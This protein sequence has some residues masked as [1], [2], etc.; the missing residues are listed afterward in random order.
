MISVRLP[1][2]GV[3]ELADGASA[4]DLAASI[5]P[6]LA[7]AA[8]AAKVDGEIVDLARPLRDGVEVQLLT[9]R[10]AEAL[11]VLRHSA[12]HL[13]ADAI[14]RVFPSAQLTIG[15]AIEDGFYYDIY[16]PDGKITP[17]DFPKI[18]EEMQRIAER[19]TPFVRCASSYDEA[20][21]HFERYR[22]IDGGNN[23]FKQEIVSEIKGRGDELTFY[24]H[25]EFI[26]LCR[27]PHVP[28]TGWLKNVK[29]TKV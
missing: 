29:L 18:E 2:G 26:D 22:A 21:E 25:G 24:K 23:R 3:R 20:S 11:E 8:V 1:D 27:G 9:K 14:L 13:M 12:A 5:G 7:R 4:A 19:A 15:P 6:G 10:D 17:D 16:Y 28:H